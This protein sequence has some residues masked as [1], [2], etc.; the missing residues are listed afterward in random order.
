MWEKTEWDEEEKEK[1]SKL[2]GRTKVVE[3]VKDKRT[4]RK[5]SLS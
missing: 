2:G 4:S 1:H 3:K 5:F